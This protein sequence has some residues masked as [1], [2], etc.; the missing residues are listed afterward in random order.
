MDIG[1]TITTEQ[2]VK[3]QEALA[4]HQ[5]VD[6]SEI[7]VAELKAALAAMVRGWIANKAEHDRNAASP[8]TID[9]PLE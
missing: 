4:F 6:P 2:A 7:G 1:W 5:G 9:N 3:I 8:I